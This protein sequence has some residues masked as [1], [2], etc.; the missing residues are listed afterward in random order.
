MSFHCL[1]KLFKW[2][3]KFWKFSAFSLEIQK[4]FS[5]TWAIFFTVG[6]NNFDNKIQFFFLSL[7]LNLIQ[8]WYFLVFQIFKVSKCQICINFTLSLIGNRSIRATTGWGNISKSMSSRPYTS[9]MAQSVGIPI[10][11]KNWFIT[12][13]GKVC[14]NTCEIIVEVQ[15]NLKNDDVEKNR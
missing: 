1:N 9:V 12:W 10:L 7:S 14:I 2:P 6:Q 13:K 3:W 15:I 11:C 4:F 5:I 8:T